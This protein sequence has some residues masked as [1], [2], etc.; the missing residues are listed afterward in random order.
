MTSIRSRQRGWLRFGAVIVLALAAL[1]APA[2]T[3]T[4]EIRPALNDLDI[5]VKEIAQSGMLILEL[6]NNTATRVRCQL[7]FEASPQQ[8]MRSTRSINPGKTISSVY[9]AQRR[10]FRVTVDVTCTAPPD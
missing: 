8:P 1:D 3:Y 5:Q 9:R 2:Q 7:V 10:W 4:V 6:T